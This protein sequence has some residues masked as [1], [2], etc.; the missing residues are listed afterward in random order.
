MLAIGHQIEVIGEFDRLRDFLENV[1]AESLATFLHVIW[2]LIGF[3][4]E[5]PQQ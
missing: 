2:L 3:V 1:N 4:P 5:P